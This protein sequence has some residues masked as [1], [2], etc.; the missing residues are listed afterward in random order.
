MYYIIQY[1]WN[2]MGM[3]NKIITPN[4]KEENEKNVFHSSHKKTGGQHNQRNLQKFTDRL[5]ISNITE[6]VLKPPNSHAEA[7]SL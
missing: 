1:S 5:R 3:R 2:G 6:I 4:A 7:F